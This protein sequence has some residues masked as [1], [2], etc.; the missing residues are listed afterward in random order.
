MVSNEEQ[1]LNF[2]SSTSATLSG[3]EGVYLDGKTLTFT[4]DGDVSI[5]STLVSDYLR[6]GHSAHCGKSMAQPACSLW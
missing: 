3:N 6:L 2:N 4:I 5:Q 1:D